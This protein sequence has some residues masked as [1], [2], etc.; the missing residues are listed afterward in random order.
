MRN[1]SPQPCPEWAHKL[2]MTYLE[3]LLPDDRIALY[4]H[5][6]TCLKCK[7]VYEEYRFLDEKLRNI[8]ATKLRPTVPFWQLEAQWRADA[9]LSD[10]SS[11]VFSYKD[12]PAD[13]PE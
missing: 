4:A 10:E 12:V 7:I 13:L 8:P 3:D 2:A 1:N 11:F 6:E 9:S 5:L